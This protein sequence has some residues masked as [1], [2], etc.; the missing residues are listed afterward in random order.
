MGQTIYSEDVVIEEGNIETE[1]T[2]VE[3]Q[4]DES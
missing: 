1:P 2:T 4:T 3:T